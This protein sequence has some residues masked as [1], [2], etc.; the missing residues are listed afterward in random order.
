VGLGRNHTLYKNTCR[1]CERGFEF[2]GT[3]M[4]ILEDS[5]AEGCKVALRQVS[6]TVQVASLDVTKM[7]KD[8]VGVLYDFEPNSKRCDGSVVLVNCKL[9]AS[10]VKFA[11]PPKLQPGAP[12]PVRSMY[13]LVVGAKDTPPGT[14]IDVR[15][16]NPMPALAPGAADPNVRN[17]PAP[18]SK[19]LTPVP[20]PAGT[21]RDALPII[22]KAW[23]IDVAG[24][25][26]AAPE[27]EIRVQTPD[28]R[29]VKSMKVTP[30]ESWFRAKADDPTPTVE[31]NLK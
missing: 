16:V 23:S 10:Q 19:G 3:E 24:K 1:D 20:R 9:S 7:P 31:V 11:L 27:Y 12:L 14:V 28:A 13:C 2:N 17:T 21:A 18:L 22:V 26:V 5:V 6:S 29:I 25:V 8:G 30:Q 15:T 4:A